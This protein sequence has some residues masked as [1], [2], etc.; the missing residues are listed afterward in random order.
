MPQLGR[1]TRQLR[2]RFWKP[3]VEREV[4]AELAFHLD[5]LVAEAVARGADPAAARAEALR[6]FGDLATITVACRDEGRR[7][8]RVMRL[9][10]W[11]AEVRRDAWYALRSLR[12]SPGFAAVA[13]LTIALGIG[14][15]TTIFGI[16]NAVLV[17][18]L[19][20]P[21][22]EG[23][24]RV[25]EANPTTDRF[26][27]SSPNYLD[28]RERAR[29]FEAL[30]AYG[31]RPVSLT[32]GDEPERVL[33][34]AVTPSVFRVLGVRPLLGRTFLE[35]E[36]APGSDRRVAVLS[37]ALWQRRFGGDPRVLG[38]KLSLD[39]TPYEVI[40]VMPPGFDFP[41]LREVWL[42]LA[43]S[44]TSSRGDH[45]LS[46]VGRLRPG[47]TV[48][49]A[50]AEMRALARDLAR[51]YPDSNKDWGVT[52]ASFRDWIVSPE[53]R[54]RVLVLLAAVGLLLLMACVN[55]ANLM[56]ARAIARQRD[57]TLR[58][59]LGAGRGRVVRQLLTESLVLAVLG[60]A[61]GITLAVL[62]VPAL[63]E[64]A[65]NTVPRLDQM[66]V[67]WRV[68]AFGAV[69]AALTGLLFGL[70]PA[71]QTS[72]ADLH[73]L[74]RGGARVAAAGR[75]RSALIVA[76][77]AMATLLLVGAGLVGGSF[78]RLM[79]VDPGFRA[80]GVL[81]ASV[82]LPNTRY[83]ADS[84]RIPFQRELAR[85]LAALPGVQ[86]AGTTNIL[87]LGGGGT[88]IPYTVE[89]RATPAGTYLQAD[90]R[91][92][93][94]GYFAA[95]GLALKRGRLVAETD[96]ENTPPVVVISER[97]AKHLWPDEDPIGKQIRPQGSR[98]PWTVVGVVGDARDQTIE[99]DPREAMYLSY[100]QVSWPSMWVLVRTAG[101]PAS[102]ANAVRREVWAID[103]AL[104]VSDV[105]PLTEQ[106]SDASAQP[107]LT[108]LVFALFGGAALALA[109]VGVYGI[110]AY[111]VAQRTREIGVRLALGARPSA[112]VAG[113][114]GH[115]ARLAA[116]GIGIGVA[117][118]WPL[119]RYLGS[120]LYE[121]APTHVATY[122]GVALLLAAAATLA[123]AVPAGGAAR[124]DPVRAL[125]EERE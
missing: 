26:S 43:P 112:I 15:A 77:V 23:L 73:R 96:A 57:V 68:L 47:A 64:A 51:L 62:A 11:A 79:R 30:G 72:R 84:Q 31:G 80:S 83:P 63:R 85:R 13:A 1:F 7:R 33:A 124:L 108:L 39:G 4:D 34:N 27:V 75:T 50:T 109:V 76:S 38:R 67:D 82:V 54:T 46:V 98:T 97:M 110:V 114:V 71:V 45:R 102:L 32:D 66:T 111:G 60:A 53:L 25:W 65:A 36:G 94:P 49:S 116:L 9:A 101:D 52:L 93:T 56:L 19:P 18:P 104:P 35:E 5:M 88:S 90:W 14:T 61:L 81:L 69:A 40:G 16:V 122:A 48:E 125:R 120:I 119:S 95:L 89:G 107:R 123:S 106:V 22:P 92:V 100:R 28:W 74:L 55:V 29:S 59:A 86:A 21:A 24:V 10:D 42:P 70:V 12:A 118:A 115:G 6:R 117:A 78:A 87:P 113:V 20:F 103:R 37:H 44:P 121:I 8:D 58:A 3:P 2:G 17:R 99:G 105:R 91:S 41:A